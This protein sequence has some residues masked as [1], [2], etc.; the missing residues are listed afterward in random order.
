MFGVF[1]AALG[2]IFVGYL[3]SEFQ[4]LTMLHASI[5]QLPDATNKGVIVAIIVAI[6]AT[7][8]VVILVPLAR[9]AEQERVT[10]GE[11]DERTRTTFTYNLLR[12]GSLGHL[13]FL[14]RK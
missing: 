13:N 2:G 9:M 4:V 10:H 5:V 14:S 3:F 7:Y 1:I 12:R 11:I 6:L 8:A